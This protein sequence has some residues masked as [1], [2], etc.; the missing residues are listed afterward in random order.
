MRIEA[1]RRLVRN[2]V[3]ASRR[4]FSAPAMRV[5]KSPDNSA[6]RFSDVSSRAPKI[7]V[8][9]STRAAAVPLS[10]CTAVSRVS[11]SI[12]DFSNT[13]SRRSSHASTRGGSDGF[14][15]LASCAAANGIT[16]DSSTAG[17]NADAITASGP[18]SNSAADTVST[19]AISFSGSAGDGPSM[20]GANACDSRIWLA[21]SIRSSAMTA[22]MRSFFVGK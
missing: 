9:S 15:D 4:R 11:M 2:S 8:F 5:D 19:G 20:P 1:L 6:R 13:R 12:S 10:F 14:S 17:S 3:C 7:F 18:A 16:D 21:S 22:R